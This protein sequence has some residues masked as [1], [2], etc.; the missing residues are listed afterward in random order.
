MPELLI[1]FNV[2]GIGISSKLML[3]TYNECL[4]LKYIVVN[5]IIHFIGGI[6]SHLDLGISRA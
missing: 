5:M 4:H 1:D 3:L 6:K 2:T